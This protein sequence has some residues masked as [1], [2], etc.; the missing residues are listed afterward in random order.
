MHFSRLQ[1]Q[2][3][4]NY[5]LLQAA[6]VNGINC[7]TG[8]NGAGKTN[9]LEAVHYLALTRGW[10]RNSEKYALKE[11]MPYFMVAGA[12]EAAAEETG[13]QIQCTYM[14]PKGKKMLVNKKALKKMSAHIGRIPVVTVLPN[15]TQLIYGGPSV[16]RKFMDGFISQYDPAYLQ[17]LIE[18]EN[19][20]QQR[21]ALLH[22]FHD[23][24]AF[25]AE[26][27]GLWD[28]QLIPRAQQILAAR[29]AFLEVYAPI[30]LKYFKAIVSDK[31]APEIEIETQVAE[32]TEATWEAMYLQN[33]DRDRFS[34]RT[35]TGIHK[36]DIRFLIDG[37][38]VKNFG[39]QGQQ[40]TF[41]IALKLAQ[42]EILEQKKSKAPVLLLDDIFD[43]LDIHRLRAI[44]G[45][46]D[47]KVKG[48]VFITDTSLERTQTVFSEV[49]TRSVKFFEVK[50]G[51][52]VAEI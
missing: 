1:L 32:N 28:A 45:I 13:F 9:I 16:R 41:V 30:F 47:T 18:Y 29:L 19:A 6:F 49:K 52:L 51:E 20:L 14:P 44:A 39:S 8:N 25:D 40:K 33:R 35:S 50:D 22:I 5:D 17:A 7:I 10:S 24:G 38:G 37:Q 21:N 11:G 15:D 27:L 42:Y 31:E 23:R 46:L 4:R 12:V 48:Q 43:K 34:Q 26:Q 36:D 2:Q 3:F